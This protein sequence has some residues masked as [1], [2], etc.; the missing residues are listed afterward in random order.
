MSILKNKVFQNFSYSLSANIISL[1]ISTIII[2]LVP[3]V[4]DVT[5]YGYFQLY[6]FYSSYIGFFHFGWC[7]GIYL[8]YGGE[9]YEKLDKRKMNSQFWLLFLLETLI[10]IVLFTIT[11][12]LSLERNKTI[13]LML[14]IFSILVIIPKTMLVYILQLTNRIKEY[15]IVT[16]VEKVL[17]CLFVIIFLLFKCNYYM[18]I[19]A[20]LIGKIIS[21]LFAI[22][23][24][25]DIVFKKMNLLSLGIKE[26]LININVGSKLMI[27]NIAGM[28]ILG[29]V[30]LAI[31]NH[32]SIQVFGK[33]SLSISIS[34]MMMVCINAIGIV[35]FP[36]IKRMD[37]NV[38]ENLYYKL[39]DIL[40]LLLFICLAFYY[41][42]QVVLKIWLPSYS[43]S[44]AYIALLFP[45]CV[46]ESKMSM[47][48]S[49]YIKAYRKEKIMLY[50]NLLSVMLSIIC[51]W[52]FVYKMNNLDLT[53]FSIFVLFAFRCIVCEL[54][55][56]S[57]LEK[58]MVKDII[59]ELSICLF[60]ICL[61]YF[62]NNFF[63]EIIYILTVTVYVFNKRKSLDIFFK[64]IKE[65]K[66][67]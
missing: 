54:V 30:R 63:S 22:T 17:Y 3:K 13:I 25:K 55:L 23:Y 37:A 2:I 47:L 42:L 39:R 41:P 28:L 11:Y 31:E 9:Y 5:E 4:I 45:L 32:W 48:V 59:I 43:D 8:R 53:V 61:F 34:N 66:F 52:L 15:S 51:S 19:L 44:L 57:Y 64:K 10:T 24:C 20:D 35:L 1:I 27:A 6:M 26:A 21:L 46:Y 65:K 38:I 56:S 33:V 49:T 36:M 14:A 12:F 62:M 7:D 58:N 16:I 67:V 60:F 40:M 18:Y 50:V 29:I